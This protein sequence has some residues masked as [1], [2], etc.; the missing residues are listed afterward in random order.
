MRGLPPLARRPWSPTA[1]LVLLGAC[2]FDP[3]G[4]GGDDG[5]AVDADRPDAAP[6]IDAAVVEDIHHV[7]VAD[8]RLGAADVLVSGGV[9]LDTT[10]LTVTPAGAAAGWEVVA[11]PHDGGG[12]ELAVAYARDLVIDGDLRVI[13]ERPLVIVARRIELRGAIDAGARGAT[14][15]P[16]GS[17]DDRG[18]GGDGRRDGA[19]YDGGGGG[20]GHATVGGAGGNDSN[21]AGGAA[22]SD[23]M[24]V[25]LVGGASGGAA[26]VD[27]GSRQ[28]GAGGGALQ[29]YAATELLITAAGRINAGGGGGGAGLNCGG[30]YTAGMGGGSGGAIYLQAPRIVNAGLIAANGGGGG[31]G[32]SGGNGGDGADGAATTQPAG[33]GGSGGDTYGAPG[34]VGGAAGAPARGGSNSGGLSNGGGGGGAAGRIIV[35]LRDGTA[36]TTSPPATATSY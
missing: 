20:G 34:G 6:P 11:R 1:V 2:G 33:G 35:R 21:G 19:Y 28:P 10:A 15:G 14:P 18:R 26:V 17:R 3:R 31:G 12:L 24:L 5:G 27:C 9:T 25:Q 32:A 23:A 16:G 4:S 30:Q 22:S 29:L 8:E 7:A 13:G 36:G